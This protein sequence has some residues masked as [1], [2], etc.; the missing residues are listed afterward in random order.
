MWQELL[1]ITD[2]F[3]MTEFGISPDP[4]EI[5]TNYAAITYLTKHLA[6]WQHPSGTCAV[7][8]CLDPNLLVLGTRNVRVV[9]ASALPDSSSGHPEA[10]LRVLGRYGAEIAHNY[11]SRANV[12]NG[13]KMEL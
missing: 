2:I 12:E 3:G 7:G 10:L 1:A 5:E 4:D 13:D 6:M 9:D 8:K 11:Q